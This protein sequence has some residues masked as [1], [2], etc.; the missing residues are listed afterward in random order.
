[1]CASYGLGGGTGGRLPYDLEP[2]SEQ[3]PQGLLDEWMRGHN[4]SAK[5]TGK[6]ARNLNPVIHTFDGGRDLAL[7][8]WWLWVGN[9]PAKFSAFNAR[10]DNLLGR[11]WKSPFQRRAI[12]PATWYIE[13]KVR[14]HLPEDE[15]FG[16]AAITRTVLKTPRAVTSSPMRWSPGTL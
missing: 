3:G 1:M 11:A 16:I 2:M 6:N 5:I 8:W 7:G 10:D 9:A 12:L 13:K 15:V 4:G 14:F